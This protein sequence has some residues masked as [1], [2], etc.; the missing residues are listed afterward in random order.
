MDYQQAANEAG[1]AVRD[2]QTGQ[3]FKPLQTSVTPPTQ[4]PKLPTQSPDLSGPNAARTPAELAALANPTKQVSTWNQDTGKY[5]TVSTPVNP[6]PLGQPQLA[7]PQ[8][9]SGDAASQSALADKFFKE[10]SRADDP[11]Y[12]KNLWAKYK[13][14]TFTPAGYQP[15]GGDQSSQ[16]GSQVQMPQQPTPT[17]D[18]QADAQAQKAYEIARQTALKQKSDVANNALNAQ[19]DL[20]AQSLGE[21]QPLSQHGIYPKQDV[22]SY[23]QSTPLGSLIEEAKKQNPGSEASIDS[24]VK[25]YGTD[26]SAEGNIRTVL[27]DFIKNVP[28]QT[29]DVQTPADIQVQQSEISPSFSNQTDVPSEPDINQ[30]YVDSLTS[31]AFGTSYDLNPDNANQFGGEMVL[32]GLSQMQIALQNK[33]FEDISNTLKQQIQLAKSSYDAERARAE[34]DK[35]KY[36]SFLAQQQDLSLQSNQLAADEAKAKYDTQLSLARDNN[37]RLEGYMKAK[38]ESMGGLDS[39]AGLTLLAKTTSMANLAIAETE[40]DSENAQRYY[41]QQSRGIMLDYTQKSMQLQDQYNTNVSNLTNDYLGR[42]QTAQS[43]LITSENAK[44]E[45]IMGILKDFQKSQQ[46]KQKEMFSQKMQIFQASMDQAKFEHSISQDAI[47]QDNWEKQFGQSQYQFEANYGLDVAKFD[48][49]KRQFGLG[50]AMNQQKMVFDQAN[51]DRSFGLNAAQFQQGQYEFE[52]TF[53][54]KA[55]ESDRDYQFRI[56]QA[57]FDRTKDMVA[58]GADPKLMDKYFTQQDIVQMGD[59]TV[60]KS[61]KSFGASV[62]DVI[63]KVTTNPQSAG[64]QCVQFVRD[65]VKDL[66]SGLYTL[67]DKIDKLVKSKYSVPAPQPGATVVMDYGTTA[68]HVAMVTSVD[69][70]NGTFKVAEFNRKAGKYSENTLSLNDPKIKGYWLSPS[71]TQNSGKQG[72]LQKIPK[73]LL[74]TVTQKANQFDSEQN[75]KSFQTVQTMYSKAMSVPNDTQSPQDDQMLV[76]TFAKAMDPSS[77]VREGEY[78]SV[79]GFAQTALQRFGVNAERFYSNS[80]FLTSEARQNIK[81]TIKKAYESEKQSYNTIRSQYIDKLNN[82]SGADVGNDILQDYSNDTSTINGNTN[83]NIDYTNMSDADLQRI[84]NSQ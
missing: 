52:K 26:P 62:L 65:I 19:K 82:L 25:G 32:D 35:E 17:G 51:A 44:N 39:S 57:E 29:G 28:T 64:Y 34:A 15:F 11:N 45:N 5:D 16:Q 13:A 69:E 22:L 74:T 33:G 76:Y 56:D 42:V 53:Q 78:A 48:E 30:G 54:Q 50:Y 80:P 7:Q 1:R 21:P 40:R 60:G 84:A 43:S 23:T 14:G 6:Q 27:Q 47:T 75:V 8:Q 58:A 4:P 59:Y 20:Q 38:L 37:S 61:E 31:A 41:T 12:A 18:P 36:T 71:I 2:P 10:F 9:P 67:Q 66:P 77:A 79:Q 46:E 70:V 83:Q 72:I 24:L 73:E 55:G 68:G 81:D 49:D 3:V 63:K